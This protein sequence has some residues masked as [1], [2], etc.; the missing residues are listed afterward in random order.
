MPCCPAPALQDAIDGDADGEGGLLSGSA[1]DNLDD[2][3]G[4]SA[5]CGL[6]VHNLN[7][8]SGYS[9]D[10][11]YR[12]SRKAFTGLLAGSS[13]TWQGGRMRPWAAPLVPASGRLDDLVGAERWGR[14][15]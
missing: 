12:A 4:G 1:S 11:C 14:V 10:R 7:T 9:Q 8:H 5:E 2:L 15:A 6:S 13:L 3:V